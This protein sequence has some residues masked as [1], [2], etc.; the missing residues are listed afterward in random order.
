MMKR[1]ARLGRA[2]GGAAA[3]EFAAVLTPLLLL[4]FGA[5]EFGRLLWT[6]EA[7]QETA[8]AAARCMALEASSCA[9]SGAYSSTSTTSYIETQAS[10][11]G[12]TLTSSDISLNG[13]TTCAG[14][15]ASNGFSTATLTYTFQSVVPTFISPLRNGINLSSTACYP[16]Y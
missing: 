8:T 5:F 13:S 7:L 16:N 11:W 10:N 3:V 6:R 1:L 9:S 14:V 4:V 2:R 12:I 15:S